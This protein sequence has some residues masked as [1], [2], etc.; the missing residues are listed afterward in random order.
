MPIS[1]RLSLDVEDRGLE[2]FFQIS[3]PKKTINL[4]VVTEM[5]DDPNSPHLMT[6]DRKRQEYSTKNDQQV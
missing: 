4:Q 1:T 3:P 6:T 2:D 5:D